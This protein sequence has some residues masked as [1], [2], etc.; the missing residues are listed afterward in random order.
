MSFP[1]SI[2]IPRIK[3]SI[4]ENNIKEEFNNLLGEV[5][6]VDFTCLN[7]KPGFYE[8]TDNNFKSAFVHFNLINENNF[9]NN[10][11]QI[12]SIG[13][14]Y[15]FIPSYSKKEYWILL[16]AKNPVENTFM[17]NAQI[18]ENCRF[19]EKK[20]EEQNL[21]LINLRENVEILHNLINKNNQ[22]SNRIDSLEQKVKALTHFDF[23]PDFGDEI[24][25]SL[26]MKRKQDIYFERNLSNL[27]LNSNNSDLI[28]QSYINVCDY[29]NYN[30]S[31]IKI[32]DFE[33]KS[34]SSAEERV[35]SSIHLCGND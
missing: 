25:D 8:N 15:K 16:K 10:I 19:L 34:N 14:S 17:N 6:R 1:L 18:V 20:I 13:E 21:T 24:Q 33:E 2:Y 23:L 4:T 7:K 22:Y 11:F 12:I 9:S 32:I 35:K 29:E 26:L 3:V 27:S 28:S 5:N 31:P 30:D